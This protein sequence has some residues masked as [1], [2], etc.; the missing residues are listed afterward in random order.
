[1]CA[2]WWRYGT[3]WAWSVFKCCRVTPAPFSVFSTTR[4]SSF[5]GPVMPPS[6]LNRLGYFCAVSVPVFAASWDTHTPPFNGP[7]SR[8]TRVSRYQR[9]KTNLDYTE[10]TDSEW[11]WHQLGYMQLCT[12]LQTDNHAS[13][14]PLSFLQAGYPSCR[15]VNSV[16]A[17]KESCCILWYMRCKISLSGDW[18]FCTGLHTRSGMLLWDWIR[19]SVWIGL[20]HLFLILQS[21]CIVICKPL[22]VL[23]LLLYTVQTWFVILL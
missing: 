13:T 16:K 4:T 15:P 11:Q 18:C 14:P 21:V 12:S 10:A 22:I 17:L 6:G 7:L 2:C 20:S 23:L 3:E 5:Q 9:G 1:V 19:L 8:T